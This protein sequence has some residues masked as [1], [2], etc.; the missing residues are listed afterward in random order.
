[1]TRTRRLILHPPVRMLESTRLRMSGRAG[2]APRFDAR[3]SR[4]D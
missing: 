1:M 3:D 2:G 4:G